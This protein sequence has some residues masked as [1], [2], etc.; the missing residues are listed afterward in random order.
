MYQPLNSW[1]LVPPHV[2]QCTV[3]GCK[4]KPGRVRMS[5]ERMP[6]CNWLYAYGYETA[7][8]SRVTFRQLLFSVTADVDGVTN[9]RDG[10]A[11]LSWNR[12]MSLIKA[13]TT[14]GSRERF[15]E[16]ASMADISELSTREHGA[17]H[18]NDQAVR[19]YDQAAQQHE[20]AARTAVCVARVQTLLPVIVALNPAWP[21]RCC[22]AATEFPK[23]STARMTK[24]DLTPHVAVRS[25]SPAAVLAISSTLPDATC[26]HTT[27]TTTTFFSMYC[28][29]THSTTAPAK[30]I[31]HTHSKHN[32]K[33]I[34]EL[35]IVHE[36]VET[37]S[38]DAQKPRAVC[39]SAKKGLPAM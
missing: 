27:T 7:I 35:R 24:T 38:T 28:T 14:L 20:Y 18:T 31:L 21:A 13:K 19:Q 36:L 8:L 6:C 2:S 33:L 10:V 17:G 16:K 23:R 9:A 30:R 32:I 12:S 26:T 4:P 3:T 39:T 37:R 15:H 1:R 5:A 34:S 22:A 25:P 11:V 29:S